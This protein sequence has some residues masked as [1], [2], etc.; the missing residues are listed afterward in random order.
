[1][2]RP[3]AS[4][5]YAGRRRRPRPDRRGDR[6][7]WPSIMAER[8]VALR[9]H[10]KTHKS[11]EVGRRQVAA[12]ASGL[13][14]GTLGEARGLRRRAASTTCSSRTRSGRVGRKADAPGRPGR[15]SGS[16]C[17]LGHRLGRG[18]APSLA[19]LG[20]D[21]ARSAARRDRL[22][23][24]AGR[25]CRPEPRR[26]RARRRGRRAR[27]RRSSASSPTAGTATPV[28][29]RDLAPADDEVR[30]LAEAADALAARRASSRA[31]V[32]AGSTPDRARLGP[33]R[34]HRGASRDLRPRR[35]PAVRR[36]ARSARTPSRR[37]SPRPWSASTRRTAA[38]RR[39]RGQDPGQGRR[40]VRRRPRGD[41]GRSAGRSIARVYDYH[42]VV[43][44]PAA[45]RPAQR[46]SGRRRRS[47]TTSARSSN[48]VDALVVVRDG[49]LVRPLAGRRAGPQRLIRCG[50]T[51]ASTPPPA[52]DRA[53]R[54]STRPRAAH[55]ADRPDPQDDRPLAGAVD[56]GR[57]RPA[58][59]RPAVE[60]EVDRVAELRDDRR[61]RRAPRAA[62]DTFAEVTGSGPTPRASARGASWSG[63]AQPDR[64]GA[65]G[66]RR[67][68][69][70]V[71]PL[72]RRRRSG[73][74]ASTPRR[75][76]RRPAVMTADARPPGRPRR[77]A[78]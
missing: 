59:G 74:P 47:R 20:P 49:R 70:H 17:R 19:A 77:A 37:S 1:M 26:G 56:D 7:G 72:G 78:A 10:A 35:S 50:Q 22:A 43:D 55:G 68:Q 27:A 3:A 52:P 13:T 25:G 38:R 24:A 6:A 61:P 60:D 2:P 11:L 58:V 15:P 41:P 53:H 51:P 67:R 66:E 39:C 9:P 46:R 23:A 29:R 44:V 31:V 30:A 63:H 71:G 33:R 28:A 34:R 64:R 5:R 12:G 16:T 73:R 48:L 65:A 57:R 8:G 18:R 4:H 62:P 21:R 76:R 75:G 14:V 45:G 36:S 42:G 40:P 54:G 32:S 69:R